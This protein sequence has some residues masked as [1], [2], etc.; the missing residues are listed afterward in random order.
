MTAKLNQH[1]VPQ[2]YFR[3]F[4]RAGRR[5]NIARKRTRDI[6][7]NA[8]IKRKCARHKYYGDTEF[9]ESLQKLETRHAIACRRFIDAAWN[10]CVDRIDDNEHAEILSAVMLQRHRVPRIALPFAKSIESIS[11][12]AFREHLKQSDDP[13]LSVEAVDAINCGKASIAGAELESVRMS[14]DV[15][16][17]SVATISDLSLAVIRNQTPFPFIFCDCPCVFYNKLLFHV[18][19]RGVLG[20]RTPG[21]IIFLPLDERTEIMLYDSV[22]YNMASGDEIVDLYDLPDISQINALQVHI[23]EE[24]TYFGSASAEQYV[25]DLMLAHCRRFDRKVF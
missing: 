5:I 10:D 3:L 24:N 14:I 17:R 2:F 11:L 23:A 22:V 7:T 20:L 21:L 16:V 9:E 19:D 8:S 18:H 6:I 15:A 4:G 1:F 25:S 12:C 13:A